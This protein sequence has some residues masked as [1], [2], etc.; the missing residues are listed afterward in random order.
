M[1]KNI[2][3]IAN[4]GK[5]RHFLSQNWWKKNKKFLEVKWPFTEKWTVVWPPS[6]KIISNFRASVEGP[7]SAADLLWSVG[8]KSGRSEK[9]LQREEPVYFFNSKKKKNNSQNFKRNGD[10]TRIMYLKFSPW[11]WSHADP[12][13]FNFCKMMIQTQDAVLWAVADH[14][15]LVVDKRFAK[16]ILLRYEGNLSKNRTANQHK[17]V[18]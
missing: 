15:Y 12:K 9:I 1:I 17:F 7:G 4:L 14:T 8:S 2:E 6:R 13:C 16:K 5:S 3:R 18:W 11:E 10:D